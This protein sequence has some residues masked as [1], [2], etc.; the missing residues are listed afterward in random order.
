MEALHRAAPS[1]IGATPPAVNRKPARS[2]CSQYAEQ[3]KGQTSERWFDRA[4]IVPRFCPGGQRI[5]RRRSPVSVLDLRSAAEIFPRRALVLG[6]NHA[7]PRPPPRLHLPHGALTAAIVTQTALAERD[8]ER[9]QVGVVLATH[10]NIVGARSAAPVTWT[11]DAVEHAKA[12]SQGK[13]VLLW[14]RLSPP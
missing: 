4:R 12:L 5:V 14:G 8:P 6:G 11:G 3:F 10:R 13:N 9:D 2:G 1:W 7:G